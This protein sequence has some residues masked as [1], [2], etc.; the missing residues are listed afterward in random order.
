MLVVK[1]ANKP[2]NLEIKGLERLKV[3][4]GAKGVKKALDRLKGAKGVKKALDRLK[5]TKTVKGIKKALE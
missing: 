3:V 5:A 2:K 4:K 1:A